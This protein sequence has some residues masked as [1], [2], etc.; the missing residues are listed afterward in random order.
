[1]KS[2]FP[3]YSTVTLAALQFVGCSCGK[4]DLKKDC[5]ELICLEARDVDGRII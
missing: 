1:M 5:V 2:V 3:E 4:W